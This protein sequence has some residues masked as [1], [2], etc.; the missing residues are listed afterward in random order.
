MFFIKIITMFAMLA[1]LAWSA[2]ILEE[3]VDY[4]CVEGVLVLAARGSDHE[5]TNATQPNPNY[6]HI[7]GMQD[8][9]DEITQVV[10]KG[11]Y[12]MAVC[13][14]HI[15]TH[16]TKSLVLLTPIDSVAPIPCCEQ[17][18]RIR[19]IGRDRGCRSSGDDS[20][21]HRLMQISSSSKDRLDGV[22]PRRRSHEQRYSRLSRTSSTFR[23]IQSVRQSHNNFRRPDIRPKPPSRP[24]RSST[25]RES[26]KYVGGS[27]IFDE[28]L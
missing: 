14:G 18:L 22:E 3:R 23:L 20:Q 9:G 7:G 6:T 15:P 5:W 4:P 24:W 8:L 13:S 19:S 2:S 27:A 10:G 11:S 16:S 21:L 26:P 12:L 1:G 17:R 28:E 25:C